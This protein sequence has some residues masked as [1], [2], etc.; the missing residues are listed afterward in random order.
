MSGD[1]Y[2]AASYAILTAG[3]TDAQLLRTSRVKGTSSPLAK[4]ASANLIVYAASNRFRNH[5]VKTAVACLLVMRLTGLFAAAQVHSRGDAES[6]EAFVVVVTDENGVVVPGARVS[7]QGPGRTLSCETDPAGRCPFPKVSGQP[8][9]LRVERE[10]YYV[11]VLPEVQTAGTLEVVLQHQQ[12]VRETVNVVESAPAIDPEQVSS[13][14]QLSGI[15]ITNIPYPNTRDYRYVLSY[16][17]GVVLDQTAQPHVAGAE[18]YQALTLLDGFNLTQPATGQLLARVSTDAIRSI[19]V[20]ESRIP[21]QHGKGPAGVLS[22]NT[23]IG[24]DHYR[25]AATNFVP[26]VQNKKGWRLDKVDPRFTVSGPIRRGE[27]W[28]FDGI[29]GEYD[30]VVIPDLPSGEDTDKIWRLANLAKVQMNVTPR[31]ILTSSFLANRYHDEHLGLSTEAPASTRPADDENLYFAGLK[32]QHAFSAETLLVVG[33]GFSQYGLSQRPEGTEPYVLTPESAFG[34]YYRRA[35]TIARRTQL[36][37]NSYTAKRWHGRHDLMAGTDLDRLSYDQRFQRTPISSLRE[38]QSLAPGTT[39]MQIP[40]PCALYSVFVD[41]PSSI[42][43]NSEASAYVQDRW[44]PATQVL[45][46]PGLRFD[47]DQFV[48]RPLLSPRLAGTYLLNRSGKS[49][50]SAGIGVTYESTNLALMSQPYAGFRHDY[51]FDSAGGLTSS[52]F[53]S[54]SVNPHTLQAP[55]FLNWSLA[56]EQ[57]LPAAVFLKT[58]FMRRTG[59]HDFVYNT[60]SVTN[61]ANFL[62]QNTR[63]DTY[64]AFKVDL[65]RTFRQRYTLTASYTHSS[66]VSNQVLDYAIDT[67]GFSPQVPGPFPWDAPNRFISWGWF[68]LIRGFD[69]GYSFEGRTGFPFAAVNDQQQI[70]HPPGTYRFPTYL[71]LN[72]H[73]EK[74]FRAMGA[75]WALRGGFDNITNRQ[76]AFTVNNNVNSPQFLTFSNFDRRAFTARIR[77]LGRK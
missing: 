62:L 70:V 52:T 2:R 4:D 26:S 41:G 34:N 39:C 71:T 48:R 19:D 58:E 31:D 51:F 32:E 64:Y 74:R 54:F 7:L 25:F 3:D 69:V 6:A 53:T 27:I 24:D 45:I 44:S 67:L 20:D 23:G 65:R 8:W 76:N 77:F 75:N 28:F 59:I 18:T 61:T 21:A 30:N 66:S 50:L 14:E 12:E 22:L 10:A 68:P 57:K 60:A 46:E 15:D 16:L 47:W 33:F 9:Q 29:D 40:S 72:F 49:K 43:H 42:T 17:P 56:F 1:L 13:K 37:A 55:R 5:S 38:G 73:L 11:L 35:H 63:T 36:L